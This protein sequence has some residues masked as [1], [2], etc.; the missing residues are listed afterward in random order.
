MSDIVIQP[1]IKRILLAIDANLGDGHAVEPAVLL[2]AGLNVSLH[3]L[4]VEDINL[5]RLASLPF[6]YETGI[7]SAIER[8][9]DWDKVERFLRKQ[10]LLAER[11]LA[12]A[13]GRRQIPWSFET[14]RGLPVSSPL[15][16]A[17]AS[18]LIVFAK[19]GTGQGPVL[20]A[21]DGSPAARPV[22]ASAAQL[23]LASNKQIA[24]LLPDDSG[25]LLRE[26]ARQI[27]EELGCQAI[28]QSLT[29]PGIDPIARAVMHAKAAALVLAGP[30][31]SFNSAEIRA[32]LDKIACTLL[33]PA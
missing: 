27:L 29:A 14:L 18:D 4:F 16:L 11:L 9:I 33:L 2:A 5:L 32:L 30:A 31:R 3:A 26:Q 7:A 23:A 25:N 12:D 21:F 19:G 17:L 22:L 15:E 8:R 1:G 28:F 13:A 20:V 6:T 24:V 10:S